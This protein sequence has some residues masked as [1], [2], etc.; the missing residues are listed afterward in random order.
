MTQPEKQRRGYRPES[1][2]LKR[3]NSNAEGDHNIA[4]EG[5]SVSI[6]YRVAIHADFAGKNS[7]GDEY[8]LAIRLNI[9][10]LTGH[11]GDSAG[12]SMRTYEKM[13]DSTYA[14]WPLLNIESGRGRSRFSKAKNGDQRLQ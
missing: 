12:A 14:C 1:R 6:I 10:R 3:S 2:L 8:C 13:K 11:S 4:Q 9:F 7:K 5:R